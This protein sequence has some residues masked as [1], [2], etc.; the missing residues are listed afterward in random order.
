V[1]G[2]DLLR[3]YSESRCLVY[4]PVREPLGLAALE[5]QACGIPVVGVAEGGLLETVVH[6]ETGLLTPRQPV[7]F[8]EAVT[9]LLTDEPRRRALAAGA[10]QYVERSWD[11]T[12][13]SQEITELF[14]H[15]VREQRHRSGDRSA[16]YLP[17]ALDTA[18]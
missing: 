17:T 12:R 18:P 9:S 15:V 3:L 6:G 8:A 13:A 4:A 1:S 5:A 7:A 11:W 2:Q 16:S 14:T 10:R